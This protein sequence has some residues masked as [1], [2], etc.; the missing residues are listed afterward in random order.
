MPLWLTAVGGAGDDAVTSVYVD[1]EEGRIFVTGAITE[2]SQG[3]QVLLGRLHGT[4][5]HL[6]WARGMGGDG[7]DVGIAVDGHPGGLVF[8]TGSIHERASVGGPTMTTEG[9]SDMFVAAYAQ[10]TGTH[11]WSVALAGQGRGA[12]SSLVVGPEGSIFVAG[13][14]EGTWELGGEQGDGAGSLI[15]ALEDG[16]VIWAESW[17]LGQH[18]DVAVGRRGVQSPTSVPAVAVTADAVLA[19]FPQLDGVQVALHEPET[20]VVRQS[21]SVDLTHVADMAIS[22][23]SPILVGRSGTAA[24]LLR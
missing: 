13:V 17:A 8:L 4:S 15:A 12:G 20:G 2:K 6:D 22:E 5:G 19:A 7:P 21:V 14:S 11:Q 23:G 10:L 16:E 24:R 1:Q 9:Q 18:L 3:L